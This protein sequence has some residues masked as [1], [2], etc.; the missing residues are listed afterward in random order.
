[1]SN[2]SR[3]VD[4]VAWSAY[5]GMVVA[6]P[7]ALWRLP[8]VMGA[9]LGTPDVWREEQS[10]PGEGTW[11]LLTLSLLQLVAIGCMFFLAVKPRKVVPRWL[12]TRVYRLV[13]AVIGGA[14]L[15]GALVL[16]LLV[17]MSVIAWDKVDPF[18]GADYDAWAWLCAVCYLLAALW[19][20]L[21]GA[22]SVGY[23]RRHRGGPSPA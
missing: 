9:T 10:I 11:Y 7:T 23:L 3:P 8:L 1:M 6:L 18:A 19:P 22:A 4:L 5:A 14:G 17:T 16:A 21:L 12:P 2:R 20:L 15:A 13:P